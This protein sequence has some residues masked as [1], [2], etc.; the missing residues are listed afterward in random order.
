MHVDGQKALA[1]I[2]HYAVSLEVKRARQKHG[3]SIHGGDER[4]TG[5]AEV[6]TLMRTLRLTIEYALRT[7]NVG[8]GC[9]RRRRKVS[10]PFLLGGDL[11]QDVFLDFFVF[12]GLLKLL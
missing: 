7:E 1:M 10:F 2:E 3:P 4:A 8:D 5:H 12:I 9:V 11:V 6:E